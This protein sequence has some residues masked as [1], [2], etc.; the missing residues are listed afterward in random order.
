[1]HVINEDNHLEANQALR[2]ILF[3]YTDLAE[4]YDGFGHG[5]DTGSFDPY[6]FLDADTDGYVS[7]DQ[8]GLLRQG[9]AV[10]LLCGFY[11]FWNEAERVNVAHPWVDRLRTALEQGRFRY[12]PDIGDII[13]E[14]FERDLRDDDP[15]LHEA[16]SPIYDKY[17]R[18]YFS[19]LGAGRRH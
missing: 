14:A 13:H 8:L 19:R 5:I 2:D 3:L 17:I 12:C 15:W 7:P 10:A 11:D 6:R 1:M 4:S 16:V 9:S 18:E